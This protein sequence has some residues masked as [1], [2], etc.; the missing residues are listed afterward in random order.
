M[1]GETQTLKW[2]PD[3]VGIFPIYCRLCSSALHQEMSGYV[4]ISPA[5]SNVLPLL[6]STGKTSQNPI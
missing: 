6:F 4:R 3:R 5:G 1:P 2:I